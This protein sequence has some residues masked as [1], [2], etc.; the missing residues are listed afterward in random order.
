MI[1]TIALA[2]VGLL[3]AIASHGDRVSRSGAVPFSRPLIY[4]LSLGIYCTSWTFFG[5]VGLSARSGFDFLPIYIGPILIVVFA[6]RLIQ[7]VV[8]ISKRQNI[9][10]IADFISARYGKNQLLGALV[11]IIAMIGVVPYIALQLKAVS[12]A[13]QVMINV[14]G[15]QPGFTGLQTSDELALAVTIAMAAFAWAFGTRHSDATEH[16]DGMILA[17]AVESIV[18]LVSFIAVGAFVT[19]VMMGG[20][21]EIIRQINDMPEL[22]DVFTRPVDPMSWITMTLLSMFAIILLPR[23]FHVMV[24]ENRSPDDVRMA[25]WLF[26]AYLVAINLFV[27][28]VA[29]A[30]LLM[31]GTANGGDGFVLAIPVAENASTV[32]II[33]FLGGLSAATAMV[34]VETV[35]LAVM[36]CNNV[37]LPLVLRRERVGMRDMGRLIIGIRRA[38]IVAVLAL[39]FTY[40]E[41]L[42]AQVALAQIGLIS[43]AAIAQFAPAFFMGL[44]WRRGTAAGAMAGILAGFAMWT[45]TLILPSLAQ[46]GFIREGFVSQGPFGISWLRPEHMF[47]VE[48]D[49]LSHGVLWSLAANLIVFFAVSMA[50][51]PSAV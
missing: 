7:A 12:G 2:Y 45:H 10:S 41:V 47:G 49:A 27:V 33:A 6:P 22:R 32:A 11:A 44:I 31:F 5:S 42:G 26:P 29:A 16:Q 20:P 21:G 14:P 51:A 48:L 34:I 50:R 13:L 37:V 8:R 1:I 17:V 9:T 3:F 25:R 4:A 38:V 23:Q 43:F 15:G 30:G 46:A 39:A 40:F 19:F 18:K 28:P 24:V 35:A 36:I